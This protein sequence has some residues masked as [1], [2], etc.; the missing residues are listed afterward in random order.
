VLASR[1]GVLAYR[2]RD[3]IDGLL[4]PPGDVAA[5]REAIQRLVD[6]P[7]LLARLRSNVRPPMTMEEH[8]S[9]METLYNQ[10]IG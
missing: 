10:I 6:D 4:L 1:L 9:R 3:G 7:D 8:A 2:V 5:W